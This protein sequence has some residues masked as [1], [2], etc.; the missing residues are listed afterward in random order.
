MAGNANYPTINP[1]AR[2]SEQHYTSYPFT[3]SEGNRTY[4]TTT[5]N[6]GL[7]TTTKIP[8][9]QK[10]YWEWKIDSFGGSSDQCLIGVCER[11]VDLDSGSRGGGAADTY[12]HDSYFN[13]MHANSSSQ[14]GS[15]V[16]TNYYR[17]SN[18][19]AVVGVAVDRVNH[20]LKVKVRR[21]GDSDTASVAFGDTVTIPSDVDLFPWVG[22]GGG[23]QSA[24]GHMNFGQDSTFNGDLTAGGN[25]DENGYGDFNMPVPSGYL[26][27]CSQ[28]MPVVADFDPA[29]TNNFRNFNAVTYTGNGG[30]QN[31]TGFGFA[32]DLVWI[33]G[34]STGYDKQVYDTT[35]GATY[36]L[37]SNKTTNTS[38]AVSDGL[39]AF[40]TDGFTLGSNSEHNTNT[41][42]YVAWGWKCNGGSTVTNNNGDIPSTVQANVAGGFSI[43]K[44]TSNNTASQNIGHGLSAAPRFIISKP[45]SHSTW[46][47]HV[48]HHNKGSI[49]KFALNGTDAFSGGSTTYE[50][51]P[52]STIF[53]VGNVGNL[54]PNN[55]YTD[56]ISYCWHDVEGV[57]KF[58]LYNGNGNA[59]GTFV[60]CGFKPKLIFIKRS[61]SSGSWLVS[62]SARRPNNDNTYREVYWNDASAEQTGADSH[63]G[64]DYFANGFRLRA[65]NAGANGSGGEYIYGAW[66]DVPFKYA[67]A[68]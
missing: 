24:V 32:P 47:W 29:E 12:Y 67:N 38:S 35:R 18:L 42:T 1:L 21:L 15:A 55:S 60:N 65:T 7:I 43:V 46:S 23:T 61:D 25:A 11:E 58:G 2:F 64:V 37:E 50:A 6:R 17:S 26:A 9:G 31:I 56:V 5:N 14:S 57:Q 62:D 3:L 39:T 63:D 30:T 8:T 28:N 68:F 34:R 40:G 49:G 19:P 59:D 52:T 13:T 53:S 16:G 4:T 66:A 48:F 20:T 33:A 36:A 41:N 45:Y 10:Y 51:M 27:L 44:W 22:S 54:M